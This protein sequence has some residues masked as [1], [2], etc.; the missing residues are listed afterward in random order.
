MPKKTNDDEAQA[1][2]QTNGFTTLVEATVPMIRDLTAGPPDPQDFTEVLARLAAAEGALPQAYEDA[3]RSPF[4]AFVHRLGPDGFAALL[5]QDPDRQGLAR[6][7]FDVLHA[8]LQN[9]EGYEFQATNAFQETV[10][11]LYDGFLGAE[12]RRGVAPPDQAVIAPLVKWGEPAFG[13]YTWP[14]DVTRNF[15]IGCTIVSLPPAYAQ[16]G[17]LAW[18]ALGHETGGHDILSADTGLMSEVVRAIETALDTA[19]MPALA[20]HKPVIVDAWLNWANETASDVLGVLNMGF[21]AAL[22]VTG[23]LQAARKAYGTSDD[24]TV[25][26][27]TGSPHPIDALRG[28]VA[29]QTLRHCLYTGAS[30]DADFIDALADASLESRTLSVDGCPWSVEEARDSAR[31]VARAI[32]RTRYDALER[33]ALA[34]IQNWRDRDERIVKE[35]IGLLHQGECEDAVAAWLNREAF[36]THAVA[37]AVLLAAETGDDASSFKGMRTILA[38]MHQANPVWGPLPI[39]VRGDIAPHPLVRNAALLRKDAGFLVRG[40]FGK[41]L[42]RPPTAAPPSLPWRRSYEVEGPWEL[43]SPRWGRWD[44]PSPRKR[45]WEYASPRPP[46]WGIF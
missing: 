30:Q 23:Y 25:E 36:G 37:A 19:D 21:A 12:D 6:C 13:P 29:A 46:R 16:R 11:D 20:N 24:R 34:S 44:Y 28:Y 35:I 18:S 15:D 31:R 8:I 7:F 9:A 39:A 42:V 33:H 38:A 10:S 1:I 41:A 45:R 5:S 27:S 32:A 22:G 3:V 17:V 4:E 40:P 14:V 2:R 26:G 43:A